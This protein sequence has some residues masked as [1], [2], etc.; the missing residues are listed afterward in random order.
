MVSVNTCNGFKIYDTMPLFWIYSNMKNI[1]NQP[2]WLVNSCVPKCTS[3]PKIISI[4]ILKI[5]F[6]EKSH[7]RFDFRYNFRLLR[8][9]GKIR[10]CLSAWRFGQKCSKR[11]AT[12]K[13]VFC[14]IMNLLKC[15]QY[16]N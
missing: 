5:G 14:K 12:V 9:F 16:L 15:F 13:N 3:M 6:L 1:P 8:R 7:F 2:H 11:Y 10:A 4:M